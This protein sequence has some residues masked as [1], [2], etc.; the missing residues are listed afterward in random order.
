MKYIFKKYIIYNKL[1]NPG[2]TLI[3]KIASFAPF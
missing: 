3:E 2:V 1:S